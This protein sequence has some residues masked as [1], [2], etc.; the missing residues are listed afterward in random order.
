M[1]GSAAQLADWTTWIGFESKQSDLRRR[2]TATIQFNS[3]ATSCFTPDAGTVPS[4]SSLLPGTRPRRC[5]LANVPTPCDASSV[6]DPQAYRFFSCIGDLWQCR[7]RPRHPSFPNRSQMFRC[8][9][10]IC[11]RNLTAPDVWAR[12][13]DVLV[14]ITKIYGRGYQV[15]DYLNRRRQS[16]EINQDLWIFLIPSAV[17]PVQFTNTQYFKDGDTLQRKKELVWT[18][19]NQFTG[20]KGRLIGYCFLDKVSEVEGGVYKDGTLEIYSKDFDYWLRTRGR[21]KSVDLFTWGVVILFGCIFLGSSIISA[22]GV[23]L[24]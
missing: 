16:E 22:L 19:V 13:A 24:K 4:R 8:R 10:E 15:L 20:H 9:F 5:R 14:E 2:R 12:N 6:D 7:G 21:V 11:A 1:P 3:L 18:F 23:L 17:A